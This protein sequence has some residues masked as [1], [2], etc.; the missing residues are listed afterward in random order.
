MAT[1]SDMGSPLSVFEQAL[2]S[3]KA[4]T[5][6][7]DWLSKQLE[8]KLGASDARWEARLMEMDTKWEARLEK[9]E[10]K[11]DSER[12]FIEFLKDQNRRLQE[13]VDAKDSEL[14]SVQ[15]GFSI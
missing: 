8:E 11:L 1:D 2:N 13:Q 5:A 14:I 15:R 12:E 10:A 7:N 9:M 6:L 3:P 4:N